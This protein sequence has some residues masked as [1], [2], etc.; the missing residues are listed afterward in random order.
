VYRGHAT[1]ETNG[2]RHILGLL[3][4]CHQIYS[5]ASLLPY[6]LNTFSFREFE[7]SLK[8]FLSHRRL[9]HNRAITSIKLVTYQAARM[10]AASDNFLE[11]FRDIEETE[12]IW[13][14]PNLREIR[15]IVD[16]NVSLYVVNGTREFD[17]NAI[18]QTQRNMEDAIN[19]INPNI[20][21]RFFWA[22]GHR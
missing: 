9:A 21:V 14:L 2:E 4:V 16:L 3:Y 13:R 5:E 19:A 15:V 8:P 17:F 10:W 7:V 11:D 22:S 18:R 20:V 6:S 1:L 12:V